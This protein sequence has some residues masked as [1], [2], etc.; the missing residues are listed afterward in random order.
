[1]L[2]RTDRLNSDSEIAFWVDT[3]FACACSLPRKR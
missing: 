1:V 2:A 3:G